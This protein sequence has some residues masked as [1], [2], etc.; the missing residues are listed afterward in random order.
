M[1]GL[2]L[3]CNLLRS[4]CASLRSGVHAVRILFLVSSL[5]FDPSI[6]SRT[7]SPN[8]SGFWRPLFFKDDANAFLA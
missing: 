2:C 8:P 1:I 3:F 5:R 7:L 6:I 4:A